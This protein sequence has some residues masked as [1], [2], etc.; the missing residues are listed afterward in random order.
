MAFVKKAKVQ[1]TEAQGVLSK[2]TASLGHSDKQGEPNIPAS[3]NAE[4]PSSNT[5]PIDTRL[6]LWPPAP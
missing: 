2:A 4:A 5:T 6:H 3:D 1:L